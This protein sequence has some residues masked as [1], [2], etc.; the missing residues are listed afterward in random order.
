MP[1]LSFQCRHRYPSG[2]DLDI[3]FE[4]NHRFTSLFGPSGSGK[5]SVLSIISGA[6]QPS[7]GRV[8]LNERTLLD[9]QNGVCLP[10]SRRNIGVVFQDALLFPHLTVERNLLYGQRHRTGSRCIV[11]Q[12]RVVEVLEL[13]SHLHRYPHNL[14]GGEKQRVALGRALLSGPELLMMD[15]P[16]ASLDDPL[17]GRILSYLE[18]VVAEWDIPTLFVTHSQ[19]E[20]RRAAH[21]V[22]VIDQGRIVGAGPPNEAL[23]QPGP[24]EWTNSTGPV[25]LLRIENLT[26]FDD[27]AI[28]NIGDQKI[29]LPISAMPRKSPTFVQFRPADVILSREDVAGLSVRNHLRGRVCQVLSLGNAVFVATDIG[30]IVW[31][32]ITPQAARELEIETGKPIVCLLKAH[33]LSLVP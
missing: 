10:P 25:N 29:T 24:L 11:D 2:F 30:Q 8:C 16:L 17:K 23:V 12:S 13:G 14:S 20:V 21:W 1:V 26:V 18:T 7:Q 4:I 33:S 3:S 32:E 9:T 28:A 22:V 6:L 27:R 5:T 15:E 19:V 31:A